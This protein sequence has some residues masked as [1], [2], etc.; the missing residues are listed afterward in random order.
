MRKK[1]SAG[2]LAGL[3]I[4]GICGIMLL[5]ATFTIPRSG[6]SLDINDRGLGGGPDSYFRHIYDPQHLLGPLG[7]IDL[8][9]DNFQRL[10]GNAI[11]FAA[12]PSLP[13]EDPY[14]TMQVAE[15]WSPGKRADDRGVIIFLFMKEKR[16]RA[17]VGY[18]Y[19]DVLTD[20]AT[21]H[22]IENSMV[23]LLRAGQTTEAVEAA[24]RAFQERLAGQSPSKRLKS[25]FR[26]ELPGLLA[27]L[28]R[29]AGLV[30]RIW[31]HLPP[32]PRM[33]LGA[34]LLWAVVALGWMLAG[35]AV[36]SRKCATFVY[37]AAFRHDR[38]GA[39]EALVGMAAPLVSIGQAVV[40]IFIL[41][42]IGEYYKGGSGMFGGG[43][44]NIF[45]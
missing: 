19:E 13:S 24:A 38:G 25:T 31:L 26:G 43:G 2:L 10:T 18:G 23:P 41:G 36:A 30:V 12:F 20:I 11:L 6:G 35:L 4:A 37:R 7:A 40:L 21:K 39:K 5:T 22:L 45:W 32:L 14:F 15:G 8:E 34:V 28:K 17:E 9:L 44:V 33:I 42:T 27:E 16:I 29:R 3:I 1:I